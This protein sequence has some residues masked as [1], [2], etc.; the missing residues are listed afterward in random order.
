[1]KNYAAPHNFSSWITLS[2]ALLAV[3]ASI[4]C[5]SSS[6]NPSR[7]STIVG[8]GVVATESRSVS[9]FTSVSL[10]GVGRLEA[11]LTGAETLTVTAEENLLQYLASEVRAGTLF[12]GPVPSPPVQ[13]TR[14]IL[15]TLT[16]IELRTLTL[17]NATQAKVLNLDNDLFTVDASGAWNV[18]V[19]GETDRQQLSLS[20]AGNYSAAGL[21][22]RV[23]T[24]NISG[25]VNSVIRASERI[26]GEISGTGLLEYFGDPEVDLTIT[27]TA[28][29]RRIGP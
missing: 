29:V 19:A 17:S 9:G 8:S 16:A 23:T 27:G 11:E 20:G 12:L 6:K 4:T 7:P 1:M 25:A 15:W 13:G 5:G 26:E 18:I 22:S 28:T 3:L 24:V 21:A 10:S 2:F 14:E